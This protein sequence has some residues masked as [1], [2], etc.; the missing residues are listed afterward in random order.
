MNRTAVDSS[1]LAAVGYDSTNQVLEIEF[2]DGQ[3][4]DYTNVS[5]E[6]YNELMS[7]GSKGSF[8]RNN[9]KNQYSTSENFDSL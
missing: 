9:I 5:S 1:M 4:Y 6:T 8:F 2:A 3:V 7:A